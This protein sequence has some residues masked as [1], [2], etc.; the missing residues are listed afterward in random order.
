MEILCIDNEDLNCKRYSYILIDA[1]RSVDWYIRNDEDAT[2]E[3]MKYFIPE[4]YKKDENGN[5]EFGCGDWK[6]KRKGIATLIEYLNNLLE[7]DEQLEKYTVDSVDNKYFFSHLNEYNKTMDDA[8]KEKVAEMRDDI[9]YCI[10]YLS[11]I[12]ADMVLDGRKNT[13]ACW[14]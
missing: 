10:R 3:E 12:L 8:V 11:W 1:I 6:I 13:K 7:N 4:Y 2:K 9:Q 14:E 5:I